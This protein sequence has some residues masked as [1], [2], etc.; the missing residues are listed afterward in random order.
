MFVISFSSGMS[1]PPSNNLVLEQVDRD[2]GTASSLL[3]FATMMNGA[4]AMWLISL[5]WH[6]KIQILGTMSVASGALVLGLW[7]LMQRFFLAGRLSSF[8]S[9]LPGRGPSMID[10]GKRNIS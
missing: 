8:E 5:N 6:D 1:R 2:A 10:D 7:F 3:I 4:V 9:R